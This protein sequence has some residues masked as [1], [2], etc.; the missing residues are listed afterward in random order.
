MAKWS[1]PIDQLANK[2]KRRFDDVLRMTCIELFS[3]VVLRSPVDTGRFRNNW[4]IGYGSINTTTTG[5]VDPNGSH[6]LRQIKSSLASAMAGQVIYF[7][8]SLPYGAVLEYGLYPNPPKRGSQKRGEAGPTIHVSGG[9]S[10]Q[11]PAGM[12]RITI[13]EFAA[14]VNKAVQA[15]Q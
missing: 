7:T 14:A 4:F 5:T 6:K 10:I 8:N 9:F 3:R 13:E 1:I 15:V 12:V 2:Y 11:A